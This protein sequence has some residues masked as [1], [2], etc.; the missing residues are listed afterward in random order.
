VQYDES[1]GM[2]APNPIYG[3]NWKVLQ[4]VMSGIASP[5][6]P[7]LGATAAGMATSSDA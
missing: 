6:V 4:V 5:I 3:K 2:N 1:M 7:H